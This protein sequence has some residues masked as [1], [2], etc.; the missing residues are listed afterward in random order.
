MVVEYGVQDY[1]QNKVLR[2]K[3]FSFKDSFPMFYP[4]VD[5]QSSVMTFSW[6]KSKYFNNFKNYS[7]L[8]VEEDE[9]GY[10]IQDK[11]VASITE[12]N[13]TTYF[14]TLT[15]GRSFSY[16]LYTNI[17]DKYYYG[18]S[19]SKL[20]PVLSGN[21]MNPFGLII[22]PLSTDHL[23]LVD[24]GDH[25]T[26]A[27]VNTVDKDTYE[28]INTLS[29]NRT[30]PT[31]TAS[32]DA[33]QAYSMNGAELLSLSPTDLRVV[34]VTPIKSLVSGSY[35]SGLGMW[36]GNNNYIFAEVQQAEFKQEITILDM[37][38][39]KQ[40]SRHTFFGP[41][42]SF[43]LAPEGNRFIR[44][45]IAYEVTVDSIQEVGEISTIGSYSLLNVPQTPAQ[46]LVI[47]QQRV[48]W[49]NWSD[50]TMA[51]SVS[52]NHTLQNVTIDEVTGYIG[53]INSKNPEQYLIYNPGTGEEVQRTK[54]ATKRQNSSVRYTYYLC[55]GALHSNQGYY[56]PIT[57]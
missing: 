19:H 55:N 57:R 6:S 2:S 16:R 25:N 48:R 26:Q 35:T 28:V 47:D 38:K 22:S 51:R 31:F 56:L 30:T 24:K 34:K 53:G 17:I 49:F 54:V 45:Q 18:Q 37:N 15:L 52:T 13:D 8:W 21:R 3:V 14:D 33:T 41:A 32:A 42:N 27:S 1:S 36:V 46:F 29:F 11:L 43:A 44:N 50:L 40:H 5:I 9:E 12:V 4:T 10:V 20:G 7:I 39:P 23:Y